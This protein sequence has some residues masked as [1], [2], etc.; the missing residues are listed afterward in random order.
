MIHKAVFDGRLPD[1]KAYQDLTESQD[2][3]VRYRAL[4]RLRT[5]GRRT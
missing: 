4:S 2:A 5:G 3:G 1:G